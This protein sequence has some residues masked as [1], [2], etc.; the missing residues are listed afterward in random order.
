MIDTKQ[1]TV[2]VMFS[3]TWDLNDYHIDNISQ[4]LF[5]E[6]EQKRKGQM[7]VFLD[8]SPKGSGYYETYHGPL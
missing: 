4:Q 3:N 7:W 1:I 2:K 6:L 8:E 5:E